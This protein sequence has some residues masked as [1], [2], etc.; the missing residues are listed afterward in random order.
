MSSFSSEPNT[1]QRYWSSTNLETN[2]YMWVYNYVTWRDKYRRQFSDEVQFTELKTNFFM[3]F[4]N[5]A[6]EFIFK[7]FYFSSWKCDLTT[8]YAK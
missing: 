3:R 8:M 1:V 6:L 2:K 5:G 7:W 4:S